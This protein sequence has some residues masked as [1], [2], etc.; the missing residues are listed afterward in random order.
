M[1]EVQFGLTMKE[2]WKK[3]LLGK[4]NTIY[5]QFEGGNDDFNSLKDRFYKYHYRLVAL[6]IFV[7]FF[8]SISFKILF[9]SLLWYKPF[10]NALLLKNRV[11]RY[12]IDMYKRSKGLE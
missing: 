8:F 9:W 1:S 4:D 3:L 12:N 11:K 7:G 5:R 10:Y 2:A 6:L